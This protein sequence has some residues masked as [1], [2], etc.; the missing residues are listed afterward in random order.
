MDA[1]ADRS[2]VVGGRPCLPYHPPRS[3]APLHFLRAPSRVLVRPHR[4]PPRLDSLPTRCTSS[5]SS[6]R[7][8]CPFWVPPLTHSP[9]RRRRTCA[10][11]SYTVCV[12][13]LDGLLTSTS[14]H[15]R[16]LSCRVPFPHTDATHVCCPYTVPVP[17]ECAVSSSKSALHMLRLASVAAC[18]PPH[19]AILRP[20]RST[21]CPQRSTVL[22]NVPRLPPS[23]CS[24]SRTLAPSCSKPSDLCPRRRCGR[25]RVVVVHTPRLIFIFLRV[26]VRLRVRVAL[27][28]GTSPTGT[29]HACGGTNCTTSPK[30]Q[31]RA[32][33]PHPQASPSRG[34]PP[35]GAGGAIS[36]RGAGAAKA[37]PR[38]GCV[39]VEA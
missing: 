17:T 27:C 4:A 29:G 1:R 31:V 15:G 35:G 13:R 21:T 6:H 23:V 36:Y 26:R 9:Y 2:S 3:A 18:P 34:S 22:T 14:S 8:R 32:G 11:D 16:R 12:P 20:P 19:P 28:A 7:L 25:C 5:A 24:A 10:P 30:V 33:P 37:G 38:H 39:C